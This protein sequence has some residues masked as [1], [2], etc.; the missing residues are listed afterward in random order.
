MVLEVVGVEVGGDITISS[1]LVQV[2]SGVL[3]Q[4]FLSLSLSV[5]SDLV[6]LRDYKISLL[7]SHKIF[8]IFQYFMST[9]CL[10][11]GKIHVCLYTHIYYYVFLVIFRVSN[12]SLSGH[13]ECVHWKV[14]SCYHPRNLSTLNCPLCPE[15]YPIVGG[16]WGCLSIERNDTPE[17]WIKIFRAIFNISFQETES[18]QSFITLSHVKPSI[19]S[20]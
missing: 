5:V 14:L 17:D 8:Q 4:V 16:R 6:R 13:S 20:T 10:C 9:E 7:S 12:Q 18:E 1:R 15:K 11:L 2:C 3:Y 19:V